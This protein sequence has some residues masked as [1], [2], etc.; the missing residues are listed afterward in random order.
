MT[1][2]QLANNITMQVKSVR[3]FPE[4]P[5]TPHQLE[6]IGFI[7]GES[8]TIL[9]RNPVG[10]DPLM[11]RIGLSTFALRK[12]EASLIELEDLQQ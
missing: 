11:V 5:E 2:D 6:E 4:L 8:V 3:S 1:L 10:G 7:A 9:R 12:K